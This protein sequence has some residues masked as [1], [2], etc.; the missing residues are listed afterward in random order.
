MMRKLFV[1]AVIS[2]VFL[3]ADSVVDSKK[4][5]PVNQDNLVSEYKAGVND[6][7]AQIYYESG[8][9][10]AHISAKTDLQIGTY[11]EYYPSGKLK[12]FKVVR[13]D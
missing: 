2:T 12:S 4:E 5:I 6:M 13:W 3:A 1:I 10:K 9:L 8:T 7:I 11:T